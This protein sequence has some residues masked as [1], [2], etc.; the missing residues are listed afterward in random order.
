MP[1]ATVIAHISDLHLTPLSGFTPRHWNVKRT[2]GL[3]NWHR[4]RRRVHRR[5]VVDMLVEDMRVSAPH[6]VAVSGD[7]C[8]IGLPGEYEAALGWLQALGPPEGVSVVPGNHDIYTR[9]SRHDG[10]ELWRDYMR[11]DAFGATLDTPAPESPTRGFPYVRR[12]GKVALIGVNSGIETRPF[13][14]AGEVGGEQRAHLARLLDALRGSGLARV[15]MIHHPPLAGQAPPSRGLTD[16]RDVDAVLARHGAELVIHGHNHR[17]TLVWS[18][19]PGAR[20]PVLGIASGS[21]GRRH[22]DEPLGRYNLIRV[23]PAG[24]RW[25]LEIVGRGLAVPHSRSRPRPVS[26]AASVVEIDRQSFEV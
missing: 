14:S 10:V 20:I 22:R 5:E 13:V 2:L 4:G 1:D 6:H 19:G 23:R 9:L 26:Q 7:L 3:L 21:A 24:N 8:N 12:I 17:D 16:A 15:V 11:S 25:H 18:D